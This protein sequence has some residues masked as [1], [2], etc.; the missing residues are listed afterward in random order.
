MNDQCNELLAVAEKIIALGSKQVDQIEVLVRNTFNID[1]NVALGQIKTAEKTRETGVAIRCIADNRLGCAFTNRFDKDT[2]EK[3]VREAKSSAEC[4]T[5]DKAWKDLPTKATYRPVGEVW[6][7]SILEK[8]PSIFVDLLSDM[9]RKTLAHNKDIIVGQAGI[10]VSYGWNAYAN[11]NGVDVADRGTRAFVYLGIVA[12]TP[13]GGMTPSI[14]ESDI[15]RSFDLDIDQV[16]NRGVQYVELAREP[17]KGETGFGTVIFMGNALGE[18]LYYSF[19]PSILGENVVRKKSAIAACKDDLIASP[20][21]SIIDNGL[22]P[23]CFRTSLFDDEGVPKQVTPIIEKGKLR[24]FLWDNFWAN[25]HDEKSTGNAQRNLRTGVVRI[26]PTTIVIPNN[27]GAL[28]DLISDVDSGYLVKG[29]QGAHSSNQ[30][31]SD[32]SVVANPCFRIMDGQLTGCVNGLMLAGKAFQLIQQVDSVG[33]DTRE[34]FLPDT[35]FYGPSVRF[36]NLQIIAK[37]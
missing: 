1:A 13:T 6:D 10:G 18:L 22:Q 28:R 5:P 4:S 24:S 27:K 2:L 3:T 16:V 19:F 7:P 29:L 37:G 23:R 9:I 25:R 26:Q 32:F 21:L 30:D 15:S 34:F 8:E 20:N 36:T 12:P 17:A 14:F 31:T 33:G 11:S 35:A